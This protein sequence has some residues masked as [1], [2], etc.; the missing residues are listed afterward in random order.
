MKKPSARPP[1]CGRCY[2]LAAQASA[3]P[4]AA[5]P[6]YTE[7]TNLRGPRL[8]FEGALRHGRPPVVYGSSFHVYGPGLQGEVDESRP[9]GALRDLAH[10]S[11]VYAEKLGEMMALTEGCPALRC[12]WAS[13][14][15]WGR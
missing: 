6:E 11:K 3:H 2:L 8:V 12:A 13:C 4:Q 14:M 1:R 7:E 15:V 10:L 5:P 9:Y